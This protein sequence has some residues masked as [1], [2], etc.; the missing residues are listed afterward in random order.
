MGFGGW[1]NAWMGAFL[2][3]HRRAESVGDIPLSIILDSLD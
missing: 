2:R 3:A 1:M